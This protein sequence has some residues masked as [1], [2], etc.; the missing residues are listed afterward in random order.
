MSA[1]EKPI[2]KQNRL[3]GFDYS[4]PG[5]YFITICTDNRRNSL[6]QIVGGGDLDAPYNAQ[7]PRFVGALKRFCHKEAKE[8]IFQRS[9][10]DRVI[11]NESEYQKIWQYIDTNPLKWKEDCFYNEE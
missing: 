2:R 8:A 10:H 11:R 4:T 5:A 1:E 7:I 6:G 3:A 9:Y